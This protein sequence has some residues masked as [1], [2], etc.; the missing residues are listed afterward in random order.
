M[1][2]KS[3]M[4]KIRESFNASGGGGGDRDK[5][6]NVPADKNG[7]E[8]KAIIRVL[9]PWGKSA[10]GFFYYQGGLHYQFRAGGRNTAIPCPEG[11]TDPE[12]KGKC[13]VCLFISRLKNA[14]GDYDKLTNAIRQSMNYWVNVLVRGQDG[15]EGVKVF[16]T[17]KKFIE[18]VLDDS[19]DMGDITHPITGR[20]IIIRR[21]GAGLKTRYRY[22]TRAEKSKAI[23]DEAD[24]VS[25]DTD[26][27]NWLTYDQM[28]Q[29]LK[30]NYG[31]EL[32]EVG[33]KF[34]KSSKNVDA[35]EEDTEEEDTEEEV[36]PKKKSIKKKKVKKVI[37][38]DDEDT[39]EEN[40]SEEDE[41]TEDGEEEE[42]EIDEDE[43]D[44]EED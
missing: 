5:Y 29:L 14:E 1:A 16:R 43:D 3:R 19:D 25:L 34:G 21:T 38:E 27:L 30:D 9:P 44:E 2:F 20:D 22:R 10:R 40:E 32:R 41:D 26:V 6:W 37:E 11:T 42:D 17:N 13:P 31:E 7:R 8:S 39:E 18:H 35:I 24:L 23:F 33:M 28:V 12:H 15:V 4:D 36:K